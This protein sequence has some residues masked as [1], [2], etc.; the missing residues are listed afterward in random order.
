MLMFFTDPYEEEII[1]STF[2]RYHFYVGNIGKRTTL[3]E[4][5]GES[6]ICA[7][8]LFPSRLEYFE[9]Q[10]ENPKY[11]AEYFIYRHT[12][13]PLYSTFLS[14]NKHSEVIEYM[15]RN[16]NDKIYHILGMTASKV[17]QTNGYK[18]CPLCVQDDINRHGEAYFHR[19]HQ[20]Q[21]ILVC[22]KHGCKLYNY[23]DLNLNKSNREF[24]RLDYNNIQ[25]LKP[26]YYKEK[27][28]KNLVNVA[29]SASYIMKLNYLQYN[30]E[31]IS[32]KFR[33]L[34]E[35]NDY[36]TMK[37]TVRQNKLILDFN[38]YYDEEF[39]QI[40]NSQIKN[41]KVCWIRNIFHNKANSVHPIR[42]ILLILFLTKNNIEEFF[43]DLSSQPLP[44]GE[45]PWPCLNPIC[46]FHNI[47]YIRKVNLVNSYRSNKP[48]GIFKCNLCG[49]TYR[50]KGPDKNGCDIYKYDK[51]LEYGDMWINEFIKCIEEKRTIYYIVRKFNTYD[52]FVKYYIEHGE[53]KAKYQ[54]SL[55]KKKDKFLEYTN[56]IVE[57]KK[58]NS[59]ANRTEITKALLKQVSWLKRNNP[60]WLEEN[61]PK[62]EYSKIHICEI[63]YRKRDIETLN[64]I[65]KIYEK[66]ITL[67]K[68]VRITIPLIEKLLGKQLYRCLN[69]LPNTNIFLQNIIETVDEF[70]I[71]RVTEYCNSLVIKNE[72]EYK[73]KILAKTGIVLKY[74]SKKNKE[75]IIEII[76]VYHKTIMFK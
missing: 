16:G 21:G 1:S 28:N 35:K 8:K 6:D 53:F 58:N 3:K 43:G 57:F 41:K 61:F 69:K 12:L 39:L 2:A 56:D 37:G 54:P 46:K 32:K 30:R 74:L 40:L 14:K 31:K 66:I 42:N 15:K 34:L 64:N 63:D 48:S 55:E 60:E 52:N 47:N 49:F 75:A 29:K 5:L 36:I 62:I 44:F 22:E 17:K 25:Q 4:L 26:L 38:N 24:E 20:M 18:Y 72:F 10:L 27:I 11:T 59:N 33:I 67:K 71:R 45:G 13:F 76:E 19:L 50:R 9:T 65:K 51:I 23:E 70:R 7:F 73:T 68:P